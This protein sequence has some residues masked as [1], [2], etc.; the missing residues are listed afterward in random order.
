MLPSHRCRLN[1]EF[2]LALN[3]KAVEALADQDRH[4]FR[5]RPDDAHF[6]F[7]AK[8]E[9]RKQPVF[10]DW[11]RVQNQDASFHKKSSSLEACRAGILPFR[12]LAMNG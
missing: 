3:D 6:G 4:H 5:H 11:I 1:R 10:E 12:S 7:V 2:S 8:I 9:N